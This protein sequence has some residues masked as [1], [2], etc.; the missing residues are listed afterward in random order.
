MIAYGAQKPKLA[1]KMYCRA[2]D[3]PFEIANKI[4]EKID[5]Y[6]TDL[7]YWDEDSG[8]EQPNVYDYIPEDL[9]KYFDESKEFLGLIVSAA[10]HPCGNIL[11]EGNIKEEFGLIRLKSKGGRETIVACID[12]KWCEAY[13]ML[14]NDLLTVACVKL[15]YLLYQ[16]IGIP[17]M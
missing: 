15:N 3:V 6:E 13:L 11:Y 10:R 12:G 7:K 1:W 14:K 4:S 9:R 8:E 5:E 16:R 17:Y 2:V